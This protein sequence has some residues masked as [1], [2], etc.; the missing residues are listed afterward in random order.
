MIS[1]E[2]G[3]NMSY[4]D[5]SPLGMALF[6]LDRLL[7]DW[8]SPEWSRDVLDLGPGN[9]VIPGARIM[10]WPEF[11]FEANMIPVDSNNPH[12]AKWPVLKSNGDLPYEDDSVG[13]VFAVNI[14]EHF[15]EPRPLIWEV[16]RVLAPGCPF[17]VF[18]PHAHSMV[19]AQDLD[20]KKPFVIDTWK[21]LL[22]NPYYEKGHQQHNLRIG[23]NFKFAVKDGNEIIVT[24]LIKRG[25][26]DK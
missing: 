23:A 13:G 2:F 1:E 10:E 4:Q 3:S 18:V 16:A 25:Q 22:H 12:G 20:H 6:G 5:D 8:V 15:W 11:D 9:K 14:L 17:N 7:P 26:G 19:Y 21:N 24:Q